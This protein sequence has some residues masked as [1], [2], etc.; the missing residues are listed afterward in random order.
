MK[1]QV[2]AGGIIIKRSGTSVHVLLIRDMNGNWTF[3]KGIVEKEESL[4]DAA[5]REIFEET[6]LKN[7][8]L[9]QSLTPIEYMYQRNGLIQKTVHYF[10]FEWLGDEQMKLQTEEGISDARWMAIEE[11][12]KLIGYPKTNIKLLYEVQKV[13]QGGPLQSR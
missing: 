4:E 6:G 11:A 10:L 3:P 5:K 12:K 7:L 13:L 2:S 1:N 9:I 8:T